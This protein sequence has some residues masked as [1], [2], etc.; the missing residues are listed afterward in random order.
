MCLITVFRRV[1]HF[2]RGVEEVGRYASKLRYGTGRGSS[3]SDGSW[4]A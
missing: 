2:S 3:G 4:L 1:Y